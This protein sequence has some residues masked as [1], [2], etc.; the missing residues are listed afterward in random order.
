VYREV[1]ALQ[2]D[3]SKSLRKPFAKHRAFVSGER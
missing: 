3:L 1:Q 2:D